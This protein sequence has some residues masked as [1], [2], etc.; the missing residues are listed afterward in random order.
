MKKPLVILWVN[1]LLASPHHDN[2]AFLFF[3]DSY[4]GINSERLDREKYSSWYKY[5]T[6]SSGVRVVYDYDRADACIQYCLDAFW[7]SISDV[8]ILVYLEWIPSYVDQK[9]SMIPQRTGVWDHHF[10]HAVSSYYTSWFSDAAILVMD[11]QW[12]KIV[13]GTDCMVIQ[14]IYHWIWN[15]IDC[16][17][18]TS[19]DGDKKIGIWTLYEMV[20]RLLN[21]SSEWTTMGLS[22]YSN[23]KNIFGFPLLKSY[24]KWIYIHD[25]LIKNIAKEKT[26]FLDR[27]TFKKSLWIDESY[28][29]LSSIPYWVASDIASSLQHETEQMILELV[30][31]AKELTGARHLCISGWVGLNSVANKKILDTWLFEDV[32]IL[33]STD[34][35]W[36]A[37][38]A[39]LY[40][41][42]LSNTYDFNNKNVHNFYFWKKYSND[43]ILWAIEKYSAFLSSR[44]EVNIASIAAKYILENKIIWWF[45]WRSES[46][47]RALWN[48][49]ILANPISK[50][51][52][53]RVNM[54]KKRELWRPLAPAVLYEHVQDFFDISPD[55]KSAEYMLMVAQVHKEKIPLIPGVTHID[56]TAR[57]QIVLQDHNSVFYALISEYYKLSWIPI[58]LNTSF[59]SAWEPI[60]ETPEDAIKMFLSSE[61]DYL[62]IWDFIL[63][64]QKM[65]PQFTF[66]KS[67]LLDDKLFET[68]KQELG[69]Y[70]K[71]LKSLR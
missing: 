55:V 65:F 5:K 33:P 38:W 60:V 68:W 12:K 61:L 71:F 26:K 4:I 50:D 17:Y 18:E 27:E 25:M 9:Y 32:Y 66:K 58:V 49:S 53:D 1:S 34:D 3:W 14:S 41:K 52:R 42:Y 11:G 21:F 30:K 19:W 70:E 20:T 46:G 35:S 2:G 39:A 24:E 48:R 36:L 8:D 56:N 28:L 37:L 67:L 64:K 62:C 22:S 40:G 16:K 43:E 29:E 63:E 31:K 23:K 13:Q 44:Q 47:P 54:I 15:K 45:Q 59:N 10:L 69:E 7:L 51:V 6:T 57:V